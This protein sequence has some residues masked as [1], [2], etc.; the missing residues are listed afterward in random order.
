MDGAAEMV[1]QLLYL[2]N[3]YE[4]A[5]REARNPD[6]DSDFADE[7][8]QHWLQR[9]HASESLRAV[10]NFLHG[11]PGIR[12]VDSALYR[13]ELALLDIEN[14]GHPKWLLDTR[15]IDES[16][17]QPKGAGKL[18]AR[19]AYDRAACAGAM[20]ILM[21]AGRKREEAA[22]FVMTHLPDETKSR[23][24]GRRLGRELNWR[25][26]ARWR[27]DMDA[28]SPARRVFELVLQHFGSQDTSAEKRAQ[29]IIS[30]LSD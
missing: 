16:G 17:E 25:T 13:L 21:D 15:P 4:I 10:M 19:I 28:N 5:I 30:P 2:K 12:G 22:R 6:S 24:V 7:H 9:F 3:L 1:A 27:D 18:G 29:E 14:G 8:G 26:V 20:Q 23:L 11:L